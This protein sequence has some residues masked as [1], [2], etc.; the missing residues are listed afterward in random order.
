MNKHSPRSQDLNLIVATDLHLDSDEEFNVDT[1]TNFIKTSETTY[2]SILLLGDIIDRVPSKRTE[3]DRALFESFISGFEKLGDQTGIETLLVTGNHDYDLYGPNLGTYENVYT[4]ANS[5][6]QGPRETYI[7]HSVQ[8]FDIGPEIRY[9]K[10]ED[11]GDIAPRRLEAELMEYIGG[12]KSRGELADDLGI[13]SDDYPSFRR[14]LKRYEQIFG[15]LEKAAEAAEATED[16]IEI[17]IS[18]IAPFNTRL[19]TKDMYG[20]KIDHWGS[21]AT[22]NF[23]KRWQPD[24]ALSGHQNYE[25]FDTLND[26]ET[27][28]LGMSDAALYG[29]DIG[30]KGFSYEVIVQ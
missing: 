23:I 27:I 8:D 18:H 12:E 25:A 26:S 16:N 17:F 14:Q 7:G 30:Q 11:L 6:H 4:L 28:S 21:I 20:E 24:L 9:T 3:E 1:L 15:D 29:I 13:G 5:S 10:F 2:D 19:D 22:K